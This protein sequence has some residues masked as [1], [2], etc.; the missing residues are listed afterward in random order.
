[1]PRAS[2]SEALIEITNPGRGPAR[3]ARVRTG[4]LF[5]ERHR[6]P[7][8]PAG[9]LE[10][11]VYDALVD[12]LD[13][14]R[15][16]ATVCPSEVARRI[17]AGLRC[18]WRDLMRPVRYVTTLLSDAGRVEVLQNGERIDPREARGPVRLRLARR[19]R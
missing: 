7:Q 11:R 2:A 13:E 14:R 8:L 6:P 4:D 18:E 1:M 12:L 5:D 17:A 15:P 9:D 16:E 19:M 10:H 3:L